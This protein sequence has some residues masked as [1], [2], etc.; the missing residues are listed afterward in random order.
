MAG[1]ETFNIPF[2]YSSNEGE[3]VNRG[4]AI[5]SATQAKIDR[6]KARKIG[7]SVGEA[8]FGIKL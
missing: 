3:I 2:E 8:V 7:I 6:F 1:I 4:K 5:N